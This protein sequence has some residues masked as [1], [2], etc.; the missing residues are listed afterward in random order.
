MPVLTL[1]W[2]VTRGRQLFPLPAGS[3]RFTDSQKK[4]YKNFG[5]QKHAPTPVISRI[6]YSIIS[7]G[8]VGVFIDWKRYVQLLLFT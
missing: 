1:G 2:S 8:L 5:H 6:F 7:V 3:F 4:H